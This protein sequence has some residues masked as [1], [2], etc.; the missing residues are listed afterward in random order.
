MRRPASRPEI[1]ASG[2]GF[3]RLTFIVAVG[4]LI[5][6]AV[7]GIALALMRLISPPAP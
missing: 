3:W 5:A 6:Q 2:M 1:L 7:S 4:V